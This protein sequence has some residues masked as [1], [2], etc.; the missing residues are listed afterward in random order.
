MVCGFVGCGPSREDDIRQ[1][2]AQSQH[3]Y[4]V[5]TSTSAVFDFAG[6]GFVHRL[7]LQRSDSDALGEGGSKVVEVCPLGPGEGAGA[8]LCRPERPSLSSRREEAVV[9]KRLESAAYAHTAQ[10]ARRLERH[11]QELE[12]R[13]R[14]HRSFIASEAALAGAGSWASRA[15]AHLSG[16][17]TKLQRLLEGAHGRLRTAA[18]ETAMLAQLRASLRA[19]NAH[20]RERLAEAQR[21]LAAAERFT[22]TALPP[23]EAQVRTLMRELDAEAD[24]KA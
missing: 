11:R 13:L 20:W 24:G 6:G 19:N 16:E 4:C 9:S 10:M 17:R 5:N 23:L 7:V 18:A 3:T 22:R 15:R 8:G 1:H 12:A 21:E 2:Y 14:R